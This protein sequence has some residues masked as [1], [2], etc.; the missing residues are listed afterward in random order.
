M[1]WR[2]DIVPLF[3]SWLPVL[4]PLFRNV[5]RGVCGFVPISGHFLNLWAVLR[6]HVLYFAVIFLVLFHFVFFV[7]LNKA[8]F[9]VLVQLSATGIRIFKDCPPL[10]VGLVGVAHIIIGHRE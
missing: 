7:I 6:I 10:V 4:P 1:T 5:N 3:T 8:G 2:V 9:L